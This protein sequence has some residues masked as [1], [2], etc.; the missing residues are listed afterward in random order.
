MLYALAGFLSL[1]VLLL[2]P[3]L[4]VPG[5]R[6]LAAA[7]AVYCYLMQ[8]LGVVLLSISGIAAVNAVLEKFTT[9]VDLLSTEM[10]VALLIVFGAGGITYLWHESIA[11]RIDQTSQRVCAAIFHILWKALGFLLL[12]GSALTFFLVPLLASELMTPT[13]WIL[14]TILLLY[15]WLLS[16]LTRDTKTETQGAHFHSHTTAMAGRDHK[17]HKTAKKKK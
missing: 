2:I 9:G 8:V 1:S 4:F 5:A 7:T 16:W 10:Y 12:L 11:A 14:P 17:Q 15:G 13:W 6:P 3:S